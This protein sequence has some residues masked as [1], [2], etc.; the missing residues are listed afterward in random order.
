MNVGGPTLS[1]ISPILEDFLDPVTRKRIQD[2]VAI[3]CRCDPNYMDKKT[4][5]SIFGQISKSGRINPKECPWCHKKVKRIC[6]GAE[7]QK[8]FDLA[9]ACHRATKEKERSFEF[10]RAM[11][12]R[13]QEKNECLQKELNR[14]RE[15]LELRQVI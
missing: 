11:L 2:P 5:E 6:I 9:V 3:P 12:E 1:P 8:L 10:M 7:V 14:S 15:L 13:E 4:A